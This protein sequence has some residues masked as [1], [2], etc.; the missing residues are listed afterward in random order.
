MTTKDVLKK[1]DE[2]VITEENAVVLYAGH[3]KAILEWSGLT[4]EDQ[5]KIKGSLDILINESKIHES[6]LKTV[7][8][9]M[10]EELENVYER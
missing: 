4:K 6:V 1:I 7:R 5:K 10:E 3:L 2:A 9:K 8:S